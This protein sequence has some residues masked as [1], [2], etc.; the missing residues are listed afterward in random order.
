MERKHPMAMMAEVLAQYFEGHPEL[1]Q[2]DPYALFYRQLADGIVPLTQDPTKCTIGQLYSGREL[3]ED[4]IDYLK[5]RHQAIG[6]QNTVLPKEVRWEELRRDANN[7]I[8][9]RL[10][11]NDVVTVQ[12]MD[13]FRVYLMHIEG[14]G[15]CPAT[16]EEVI[17]LYIDDTDDY[18]SHN[19]A[20]V[21]KQV[22]DQFLEWRRPEQK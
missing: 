10:R 22:L 9:W 1:L 16:D 11:Y 3:I 4:C 15:D 13:D 7:F 20:V 17:H 8:A 5:G 18:V 12:V 14:H 19:E 6:W 2:D 21:A